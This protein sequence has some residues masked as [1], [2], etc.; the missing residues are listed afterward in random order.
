MNYSQND[1][2]THI[3]NKFKDKTSGT[4][5]DIGAFNGR[6]ASNTLALAERGWGRLTDGIFSDVP[7]NWSEWDVRW[8]L[9]TT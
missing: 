5:L 3:I 4:F 2:E 1:E 7:E 6:C 9:K 8:R